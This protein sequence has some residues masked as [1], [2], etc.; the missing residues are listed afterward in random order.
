MS[1]GSWVQSPVWPSFLFNI[2]LGQSQSWRADTGDKNQWNFIKA[3]WCKYLCQQF[4]VE[5]HASLWLLVLICCST[6]FEK[7]VSV[8]LQ[9]ASELFSWAT[10]KMSKKCKTALVSIDTLLSHITNDLEMHLLVQ[11]IKV[12]ESWCDMLQQ[13]GKDWDDLG[14]MVI[15]Y[16]GH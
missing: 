4:Q 1:G 14:W 8:I 2:S 13:E 16:K 5:V 7:R 11:R 3:C 12:S 9:F 10:L 15:Q 6:N